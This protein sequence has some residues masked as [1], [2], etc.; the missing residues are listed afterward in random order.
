MFESLNLST[1][2]G[3][4]GTYPYDTLAALCLGF[5]LFRQL[6]RG[7]NGNPNCLP[8]PP[9]PKGFPLIGNLFDMPVEKAWVVYDE[10]RKTYGIFWFWMVCHNDLLIVGRH[11][12]TS[13]DMIYFNVL[14]QHFMILS[15]LE[16]TTDLFEKR[17]SNYSDRTQPTMMIELWVSDSFHLKKKTIEKL[18]S[19][20]HELGYKLRHAAIQPMVAKAQEIIPPVF[21]PWRSDQIPTYSTTRH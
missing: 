19:L 16:I 6:N 9:G 1:I 21:P 17:S 14:G 4:L 7:R 13:G 2:L 15:S 8:L 5:I 10:W 11:I 20:Q 18:W 12:F 3:L